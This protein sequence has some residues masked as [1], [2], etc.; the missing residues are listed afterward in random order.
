VSDVPINNIYG[1]LAY[2]VTALVICFV[3][4]LMFR[5]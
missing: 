3:C 4:W 1:L 5:K 2:V